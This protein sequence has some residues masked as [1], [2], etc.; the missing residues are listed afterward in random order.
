M[1]AN[2][3]SFLR[4]FTVFGS[5][6]WV[7]LI[8]SAL[9]MV[10]N[11]RIG[12]AGYACG[13]I[14]GYIPVLLGCGLPSFRYGIDT[15]DACKPSLG[16]RGALLPL[17]GLIVNALGWA[18]VVMSMVARGGVLLIEQGHML[19]APLENWLVVAL[20]LTIIVA[21]WL[22]LRSGLNLVRRLNDFVGPALIVLATISL[23]LLI[24]R[25]GMHRL[26]AANIRPDGALTTDSRKSLAYAVEFGIV[27]SMSWWPYVGGLYR[28]LKHRRHAVGPPIIGGTLIGGTYCSGIAALAAV[29][30]ATADPV[31]WI[32]AL[33]GKTLG[34][35]VVA[36]ILLMNVPTICM[37][38]YFAAVSIQQMRLL[39]R[40]PWNGLVAL[41][42]IPLVLVAF[43]TLWTVTHV[44]T[45]AT[46]CGV[47]FIAV[48]AIGIVDF[49]ILRGQSIAMDQV[50]HRGANGQY[51]FWNGINYPAIGVILLSIA[52]YLSLYNPVTLVTSPAFRYFGAAIPIMLG[53]GALYYILTR[54]VTIPCSR[55]GYAS[56][57]DASTT[58]L[59]TDVGL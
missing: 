23:C 45:I 4:T 8:G 27:S 2:Y 16:Q 25:F 50:F 54:L 11:T 34:T 28:L 39:A 20:C 22:L 59:T 46:Y 5:A 42:L 7:Y 1:Y 12:I 19:N 41:L 26:W 31:V 52:G 49:H 15:I 32:I 57:R 35:I 30:C 3:G 21:C 10:G 51:W 58:A 47:Q 56:A 9:P 38:I 37:L 13:L 48:S 6:L 24:Q 36:L 44:M 18:G 14:I 17:I 29:N 43:H 33:A 53:S 40:L 55:G